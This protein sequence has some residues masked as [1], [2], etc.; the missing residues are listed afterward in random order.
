MAVLLA[1]ADDVAVKV[2]DTAP[3]DLLK[4]YE[5]A[6]GDNARVISIATPEEWERKRDNI[7]TRVMESL[8]QGPS[9]NP[10]LDPLELGREELDGY[11]R[12]KVRYLA[13]TG[14][15]ILAYLLV[16]P[17]GQQRAAVIALHET[18]AAGKNVVVG[19]E[20]NPD[21]CFGPELVKRGY[22]VLA[23]DI[24]AA[25]ERVLPGDRAIRSTHLDETYPGWS[26]MG[27]MMADH[28]R[29]VDYLETLPY[30]NRRKIAVIGHSL[31]GYNSLFLAAFDNRISATVMS[32]GFAPMAGLT[33]TFGWARRT[34]F[35]HI[36][37][38]LP[39]LQAGILPWDLHEVMALIAPR[40]LFNY[41]AGN[42]IYFPNPDGIRAGVRE[43]RRV[44]HLYGAD[45]QFHFVM[46]DRTH[47]F[48]PDRR[49]EAYQF[50]DQWRAH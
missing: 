42:D 24:F 39:Y 3:S 44:Y 33:N 29:G 10:P 48:P 50:L 15:A 35:V 32:C 43:V 13:G 20:P 27:K 11:T 19:L 49:E 30:V 28:M 4:M 41:S 17:G 12:I 23:P 34:G 45:G 14:E 7:R 26:A 47:H 31:G 8:G 37:R 25:G 40:P 9:S 38:L 46:D 16:P 18:N 36:P 2:S 6:K 1:G 5:Q 22:V 21:S